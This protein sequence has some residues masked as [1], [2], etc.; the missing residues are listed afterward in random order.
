MIVVTFHV[1]TEQRIKMFKGKSVMFAC[2]LDQVQ[3]ILLH[4]KVIKVYNGKQK[5]SNTITATEWL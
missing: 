5:N 2:L 4:R 3:L 1:T